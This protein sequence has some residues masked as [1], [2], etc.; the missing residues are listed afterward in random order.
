MHCRVG[1]DVAACVVSVRV[2][3]RELKME[4]NHVTG[5]LPLYFATFES[6]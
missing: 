4:D 3:H 1:A 5:T 2:T 6:L